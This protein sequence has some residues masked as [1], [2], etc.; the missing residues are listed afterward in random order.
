MIDDMICDIKT[1]SILVYR[2]IIF[3]L[4]Y[5]IRAGWSNVV[6]RTV[7]VISISIW[8]G[9]LRM[10]DLCHNNYYQATQIQSWNSIIH[11]FYLIS[12]PFNI[13]S[14][15]WLNSLVVWGSDAG[16]KLRP[17]F[18]IDHCAYKINFR[19]GLCGIDQI[20][21]LFNLS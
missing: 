5:V 13:S 18:L 14:W 8:R 10:N 9:H 12:T 21:K 11:C 15:K 20:R 19:H 7:Y 3:S 16:E 4:L 6:M 17:F 2:R 1:V